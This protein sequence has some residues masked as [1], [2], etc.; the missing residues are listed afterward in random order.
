MTTEIPRNARSLVPLAVLF[1]SGCATVPRLADA[2]VPRTSTSF[3]ADR[4]VAATGDAAWPAQN[5]WQGYGDPQLDTL[6]AE[7]LA[8][9]PD[10][11]AATARVAQAEGY[12]QQAGAA[13]LPT[14]GVTGNAGLTK[15]S[16][17]NGIPADFV[18]KGWNDTGRV[19]GELGFDLDL[20]GR[21]RAAFAAARSDA[22]AARLDL[23]QAQLTLST[24]IAD[25]YADLARLFAERVVA[26]AALDVRRQTAKLT[27]DRVTGG[28][29][30]RAEQKQADSA[31]PAARADVAATDEAIALTRNRI[32][33]LLGKGPDRGLAIT[34]PAATIAARGLPIGVTTDLIARRPD[35]V[36]ART[37]VEAEAS[38]IKVARADFYPAFNLSAVF[39]LQSLGLS[40]LIKGGSTAGSI[41]P[42]FSLPIFRGGELQGRYRVARGSYDAAVADYDR[43]VTDAYRAVAD[44]VVSQRALTTRLTESQQSLTDAQAGYDVARLRFEGGLSRFTDVLVAQDRVLQAR[45]I[46][47][48][49]Q[50]RAFTLDIALVRALGGGFTAPATAQQNKDLTHG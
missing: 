20:W 47:A 11:A 13:R 15:Q 25:A 33:A 2:P 35:I 12:A 42:A 5:W 41:G 43:T 38:R 1:L 19:Q 18:P 34:P 14:L 21:N 40:N 6:I 16:Y 22:A 36:A 4:S 24:N 7:A 48:D 39:G 37:R 3:A 29:D 10:L 9:S 23:A 32:A 45:R 44:A 8:G 28:L 50:A 26:L 17:N 46:V 27:A 49:L 31:V 30:T